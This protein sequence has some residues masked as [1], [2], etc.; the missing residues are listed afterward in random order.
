MPGG[1]GNFVWGPKFATRCGNLFSLSSLSEVRTTY[2]SVFP[3]IHEQKGSVRLRVRRLELEAHE[4]ICV[5]WERQIERRHEESDTCTA[6]RETLGELPGRPT[7][8]IESGKVPS[9]TLAE[10]PAFVQN[11]ADLVR[12][13]TYM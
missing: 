11:A 5:L 12:V 3:A 4:R 10:Q 8:G 9:L 6:A 1:T 7:A 2:L 13:A